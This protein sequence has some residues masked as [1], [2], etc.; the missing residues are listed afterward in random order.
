M[1]QLQHIT[2]SER[3]KLTILQGEGLSIRKI[4]NKVR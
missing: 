2:S 4:A 1:K 3:D